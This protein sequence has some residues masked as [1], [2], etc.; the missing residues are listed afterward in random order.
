MLA[1]TVRAVI[2]CTCVSLVLSACVP[3]FPTRP[4]PSGLLVRSSGG[5]V[6]LLFC[7]VS[8]VTVLLVY[9]R[10]SQAG[11]E[12]SM[13]VDQDVTWKTGPGLPL[14]LE[15]LV[16]DPSLQD[17]S[18]LKVGD[19]LNVAITGIL[20]GDEFNRS[21]VISVDEAAANALAAGEWLNGRG[22][23]FAEPCVE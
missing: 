5:V 14:R 6:D 18:A 21:T 7:D 8:E 10:P 20:G 4:E 13:V 11:D 3:F 2:V 1:R 17:T 23:T 22:E 15:E 9:R 16:V 12:Y 19:D